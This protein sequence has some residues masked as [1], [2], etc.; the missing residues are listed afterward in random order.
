VSGV[1]WIFVLSGGVF[2]SLLLMDV[3]LFTAVFADLF[4]VFFFRA[5]GRSDFVISSL[6]FS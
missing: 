4:C 1:E 3:L 6:I 2:C 5:A